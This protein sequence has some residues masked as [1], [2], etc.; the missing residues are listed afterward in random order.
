MEDI[1][2]T[3]VFSMVVMN[4][5]KTPSTGLVMSVSFQVRPRVTNL[6]QMNGFLLNLILSSFTKSVISGFRTAVAVKR[7][8][9]WAM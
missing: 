5:C 2:E 7:F 8:I 3:Y 4:N 1:D 9:L 6:E